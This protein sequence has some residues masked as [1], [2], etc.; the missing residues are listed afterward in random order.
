[1]SAPARPTLRAVLRREVVAVCAVA[2]LADILAGIL[3]AT[4]SLNA[5]DLGPSVVLNGGTPR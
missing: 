5:A 3:G 2:F 1:V 4:F